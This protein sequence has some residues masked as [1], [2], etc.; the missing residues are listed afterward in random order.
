MR[1]LLTG[2]T[3]YIGGAVLDALVRAGHH[4]T[5]VVRN[6][7]KARRVSARGAYPVVGT[8]AEPESYSRTAE[9]QDG[10]VHTAFDARSGQ[11]PAIDRLVLETILAAATRPGAAGSD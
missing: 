7:E 10:Y 6:S 3:G 1:I 9:A 2:A 5:A 11:G 8:L 4:V